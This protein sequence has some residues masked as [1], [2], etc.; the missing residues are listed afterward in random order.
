MAA[1]RMPLQPQTLAAARRHLRNIPVPA[2]TSAHALRQLLLGLPPAAAGD[3]SAPVPPPSPENPKQQ[4]VHPPLDTTQPQRPDHTTPPNPPAP[5]LPADAARFTAA[6]HRL[7]AQAPA[8]D[9]PGVARLCY[10]HGLHAMARALGS[11]AA[12]RTWPRQ[13]SWASAVPNQTSIPA[14]LPSILAACLSR[15]EYGP[16]RRVVYRLLAADGPDALP[17]VAAAYAAAYGARR[18]L[19][20]LQEMA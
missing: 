19:H 17:R 4:E 7:L 8:D 16:A 12:R 1:Q 14:V 15:G 18:D 11:A 13:E 2:P 20:L 6:L 3:G 5:A 10:Q 9:L